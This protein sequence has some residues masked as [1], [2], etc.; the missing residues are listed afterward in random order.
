MNLLAMTMLEHD[1]ESDTTPAANGTGDYQPTACILCESNCGIEVRVGADGRTFDRIRGDKAHP[2]SQGYTCE[3]A[4]RLDHYGK[5][6]DRIFLP[7]RRE[8]DGSFTELSWEAAISEIAERLGDVVAKHGGA[9]VVYYG[10]GGQGNHLS[11]SYSGALRGAIGMK[12]QSNALAQEKTGEFWVNGKMFGG[13][14]VRGEFAHAEVA[15][16]IGKNPWHTHGFPHARTTLK[17]IANDPARSII[18]IDPRRSETADL[19]DIHL[20][21]RPGTDAWCLAALVGIIVQEGLSKRAWLDEHTNGF[22][23]IAVLFSATPVGEYAARCGVDEA[24]LRQAARRIATASS[25]AVAEDLGIQHSPHSTL[26]SYIEKLVWLLGGHFATPGTQYMPSALISLA[27]TDKPSG[28][29]SGRTRALV[30]PVLGARVISGL[31]PSAIIP[32]EILTDHPDRFR[33]IWIESSNPVHSLPD[34]KKW[35]EAMRALELSVVIDVAMTET[36][37]HADYVLP[38]ANQFEKWEATFFNFEFPGNVFHLRAP[39]LT[40]PEG[41]LTEPELYC[42]LVEAMGLL[43]PDDI[44]PLRAA[45]EVSRAKFAE[46][47]FTDVLASPRLAKVMPAV[48]YR[49][50]G[51][52]LPN[53]AASAALLWA[54]CHK[55]A[56]SI[57]ESLRRAGITGEGLELGEA[58]FDK[59]LAS[60][61]G[62][63][64]SLDDHDESWRRIGTSDGRINLVV[65]ELLDELASLRT[66]VEIVDPEFPMRLAAG[67]RRSFT[68]NTIIREPQWRKRDANGALRVHP[69]DAAS[70]GLVDGGRARVVTNR[71]SAIVLV[72]V[73]DSMHRGHMSL[74]NGMGTDHRSGAGVERTGVAANE[75]TDATL[76]DPWAGTPLHK[77]VP[78]RLESVD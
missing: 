48:L 45:A 22:D 11:G 6:A 9:S 64:F 29:A 69:D 40:A 33:A 56:M 55:C 68:A 73:N 31:I 65:E 36:G 34:S 43:T 42:R 20:Q 60:P 13:G 25:V 53:G 35:Q 78:A 71:G 47:F 51:P 38:M 67:E 46:A 41:S 16:F 63:Q 72:E 50:L 12:Y 75:L 52:T 61:H 7:Q 8:A 17:E 54:A 74:P 2:G 32:E 59:V 66:E 76:R 1:A 19:A 24:L 49:A 77:N 4:L 62:L 10:G 39:V 3:K 5:T 44:A 57:P 37:R 18:V 15:L 28:S 26:C 27:G 70:V 21:V 14:P 23:Q 58:L 30:S